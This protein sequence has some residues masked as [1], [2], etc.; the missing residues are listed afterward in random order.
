VTLSF[1]PVVLPDDAEA[2]IEF[3]TVNEWP[4][5][6]RPRLD[7]AHAAQVA[8]AGDDVASFWI[9]DDGRTVGLIRALDLDDLAD[10]SPLFDVRIGAR[11]RGRGV[12]TAAVA[13]LTDHLFRTHDEL[14]RIEASTRHD[15]LAMQRVFARCGYRREGR[16]VEAW[17]QADGTRFDALTYAML[18]REWRDLD[19]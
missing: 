7:A 14:H 4:Y 19:G 17:V 16:M 11:D 5:H 12:G 18:R 2:A 1:E 8:L 3:L 10:G 13:W 6:G 9:R 15:N